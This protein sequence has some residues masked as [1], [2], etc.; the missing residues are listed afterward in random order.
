MISPNTHD[1]LLPHITIAP[2]EGPQT[3]FMSSS[4]DIVFYGG[5]AGGG[6]SRGL[7]MDAA[8][9]HQVRGYNAVI[10]RKSYGEITNAGGLWDD[11][12]EIYPHLGAEPRQGSLDWTWNEYN[13]S[14]AFSH[15]QHAKNKKTWQGSQIAYIGWDE[16]THF[17]ADIFFYMLS[18]NRS[19]CGVK[20]CVRATCNPEPDSWVAEFLD[21]WIGEDGFPIPERDGVVRWFV[22]DGDK[23]V[24]ADAP[25]DFVEGED[26]KSVT[27]IRSMLSDNPALMQKDPSYRASLKALPLFEREILEKGN[28]KVRRTGGMRFRREWFE[29]IDVEPPCVEMVRYW[30]RAG[31]AVAPSS[32]EGRIKQNKKADWT[33]GVK[34]GKTSRGAYVICDVRRFQEGAAKMLANV[35][36]TAKQDGVECS[37]WLEQDPGSAG[38][39]EKWDLGVELQAF[40]PHFVAPSGSKWVRSGRV[41]AASENGLIKLV[42]GPWNKAFLDEVDQ[43]VDEA[44]VDPP[45]GYHD[46]Q[47]DSLSGAYSRLFIA[48]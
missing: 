18:R 33:A 32:M 15:F 3:R 1:F 12:M 35:L 6:K 43:F 5:G 8:R 21:W 23:I 39:Y 44:F 29:I 16:V 22:R 36:N 26:P 42:R 40:S 20:P 2:Q 9:Y 13:S 7:L 25:E 28:W 14:V 48:R 27:F 46:D 41:S 11:S 17:T 30:D 19:T 24:W 4:A 37:L 38:L 10:F 47:V 31:T 45:P 34:M